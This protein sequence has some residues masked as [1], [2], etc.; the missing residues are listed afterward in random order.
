MV[1]RSAACPTLARPTA[2]T[3]RNPNLFITCH[4]QRPPTAHSAQSRPP[5]SAALAAHRRHPT[6]RSFPIRRDNFVCNAYFRIRATAADGAYPLAN[7]RYLRIAAERW[8]V[9]A[10]EGGGAGAALP[11]IAAI[12]GM[13]TVATRVWMRIGMI[14]VGPIHAWPGNS[15]AHSVAAS[16][17]STR[18]SWT[19]TIGDGRHACSRIVERREGHSAGGDRHK[20][21]QRKY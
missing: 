15:I 21:E 14:A 9:F 13:I 10:M 6:W 12:V 1:G 2:A 4:F 7:A 20:T 19:A 5:K 8:F 18:S 11:S 16:V 17:G 3:S